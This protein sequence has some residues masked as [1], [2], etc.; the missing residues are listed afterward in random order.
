MKDLIKQRLNE[1]LKGGSYTLYHGSPK[2]INSFVDDFVGGAEAT[3]QEGPGIYFTN[4][5][6][7]AKMYGE[8]IHEAVFTPRLLWDQTPTNPKKLRPLVTKMTLAAPDWE[9]HA[10]N[11]D[12]NPRRGA[13]QFVES[14][15]E[16]NDTEKDVAQQVWYDFYKNNPVDFVRNMVKLGVDGLM[17]KRE[18]GVVHFIIYNP[19]ALKVVG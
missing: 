6:E 7:D 3:D 9:M 5:I 2:R 10:Q 15:L 18:H 4:S 13:M 11:Y 17:V 12:E 14:A 16:Y 1:A 8:F 19:S